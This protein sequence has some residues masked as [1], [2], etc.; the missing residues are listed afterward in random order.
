MHEPN[1]KMS[2]ATNLCNDFVGC[3]LHPISLTVMLQPNMPLLVDGYTA[4]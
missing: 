2:V 3:C 4:C 1:G